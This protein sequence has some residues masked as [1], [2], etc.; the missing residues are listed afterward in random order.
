MHPLVKASAIGGLIGAVIFAIALMFDVGGLASSLVSTRTPLLMGTVAA[1]K[2]STISMM[3]GLLW[4][5]SFW[6]APQP[7][8]VHTLN[9]KVF[10]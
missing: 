2:V 6:P 10:S 7:K 9:P 1:I 8:R 5:C 3:I 4:M